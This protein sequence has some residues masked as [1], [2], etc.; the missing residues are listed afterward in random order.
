MC[1]NTRRTT[2][3]WLRWRNQI[4]AFGNSNESSE[5]PQP[6]FDLFTPLT[7]QDPGGSGPYRRQSERLLSTGESRRAGFGGRARRR[8]H[9][10]FQD[11]AD[12]FSPST[13]TSPEPQLRPARRHEYND[14]ALSEFV[15]KAQGFLTDALGYN[16]PVAPAASS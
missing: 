7:A 14:Y 1:L 4:Q 2:Q 15:P 9:Q 8:A 5:T 10:P 12:T 16:G 6:D 11:A 3:P 13:P